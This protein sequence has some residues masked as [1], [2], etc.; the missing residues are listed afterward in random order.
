MSGN[1]VAA[2]F[3]TYFALINFQPG[4]NVVSFM[5]SHFQN[6]AFV[7]NSGFYCKQ[8]VVG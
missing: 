5:T 1:P 6:T 7:F 3:S 8:V 2:R 4:A